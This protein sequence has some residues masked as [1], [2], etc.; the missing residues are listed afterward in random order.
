MIKIVKAFCLAIFLFCCASIF[1]YAQEEEILSFH[2][3]IEVHQDST[4]TVTE[5][6]KVK[7]A[8]GKGSR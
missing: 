2:S 1:V 4:M 8:G 6:I 7:A 5:T 3:D